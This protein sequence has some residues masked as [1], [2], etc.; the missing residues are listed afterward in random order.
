[1]SEVPDDEPP[2]AEF[3]PLFPPK[4]P[5]GEAGS[6]HYS[7]ITGKLLAQLGN[8]LD[9]PTDRAIDQLHRLSECAAMI[10]TFD[11]RAR[12]LTEVEE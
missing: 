2:L 5:E 9:A 4:R 8:A 12:A 10:Q 3:H 11:M 1:M 6:A 7:A